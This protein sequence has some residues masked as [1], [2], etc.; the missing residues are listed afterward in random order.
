MLRIALD[1]DETLFP[2]LEKVLEVYNQRHGTNLELSQITTYNLSDSFNSEI[3]DGLIELFVDKEVYSS[4][5]P[6][7]GAVRAIKTLVE[8]GHEIYVATATDVRN[9][10]WKE[11]LLRKHFPFIPKKNLIRI[12]KKALLNVDVLV[13]DKLENLKNTF[14]HQVCFNQPWNVDEDSDYVYSI[15]RIHHWGEINNIIQSIER[16]EK[17]WE[18]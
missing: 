1:F 7:K 5:Q 14:A 4:L 8:Q 15:Y 3:A 12:H 2:T 13:E 11:E 10:E 9:M 18:K 16:K 17:E 6:Y